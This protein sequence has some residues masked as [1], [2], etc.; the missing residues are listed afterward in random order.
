MK[1]FIT[2]MPGCGKSTFGRKVSSALGVNFIDLDNEI[3]RHENRSINEIFES[4]GESYFREIESEI[5]RNLTIKNE[6]F[7]MATGGGTPCFFDNINFMNDNGITIY[8]KTEI[9]D[10]LDRLSEKGKNK[11]PLLKGLR[12]KDLFKELADKLDSRKYYY[13]KSKVILP[14]RPDLEFEIIR[15]IH[16]ILRKRIP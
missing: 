3:I 12:R 16:A 5:L 10:L 9:E 13:E 15:S 6:S 4:N 2:G 11:R 8:I 7:I 14:Y 1:V